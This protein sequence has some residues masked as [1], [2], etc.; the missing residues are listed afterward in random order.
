[1]K[2]LLLI[3]HGSRKTSSN[4]EAAELADKLKQQDSAF[5]LVTHGFLE[6]TTPKV[7]DAVTTLVDQGATEVTILP[8]FLAAGMHVTEDLPE[9]LAEAKT[10]YPQVT[11]TLLEHLGAA[12]LMPS[13]ILQ[14]ASA[15]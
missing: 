1:M 3:A 6:L 7:P 13:W 2:A 15:G 4:Q 10:A 8:Y 9:L 11:F 14:Q 12:Q 5:A